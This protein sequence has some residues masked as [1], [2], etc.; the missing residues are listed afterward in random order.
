MK[1]YLVKLTP[2]ERADLEALTRKGT[3]RARQIKRALILL[4][5]DEGEKDALIAARVRVHLNTV[6]RIRQRCAAEGL[7]QALNERPRPGNPRRLDG[8]QEADVIALACSDPPEGRG[9]WTMQLLANRLVELK[10]VESISDDTVWRTLKRGPLN[11]G[12]AKSGVSPA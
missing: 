5:A 6:V 9:K 3:A 4:A 11:P 1:K 12:N 8:R 10:L 2:N 7:E